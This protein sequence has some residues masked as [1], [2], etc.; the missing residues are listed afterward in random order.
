MDLL[1]LSYL[2]IKAWFMMTVNEG[3]IRGCESVQHS[4]LRRDKL[5]EGSSDEK[6]SRAA[7]RFTMCG[8]SNLWY[9]IVIVI[10]ED[11]I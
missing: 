6:M 5:Y 1:K 8:L 3:N 7:T 4:L 2:D 10:A 9:S 11:E